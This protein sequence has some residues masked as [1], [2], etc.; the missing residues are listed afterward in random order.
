[1]DKPYLPK[2]GEIPNITVLASGAGTLFRHL[3]ECTHNGIL[4]A[5]INY[6]VADRQCKAIQVAK[7]CE[8]NHEKYCKDFY[9]NVSLNKPTLIVMAGFLRKLYIPEAFEGHVL[10]IHPSLLPEF[11]GKGMYGTRVHEAVM[12]ANEQYSGCTVHIVDN[13]Y[14][15]GPIL[16]SIKVKINKKDT[17]QSL[18]NKVKKAERYLYPIIIQ[19]YLDYLLNPAIV[20]S[21][22]G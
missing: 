11:G 4:R 10:N 15:S 13:E 12:N 1:M 17:V 2:S 14:D 9:K 20:A 3:V 7:D 22:G 18:E 19:D 5:N 21:G 6:F 16:D 8:I